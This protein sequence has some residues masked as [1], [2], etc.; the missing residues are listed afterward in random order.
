MV[1]G[2]VVVKAGGTFFFFDFPDLT[3]EL[4][5]ALS[6]ISREATEPD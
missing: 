2:V 1:I 5:L 4:V 6:D 3:D